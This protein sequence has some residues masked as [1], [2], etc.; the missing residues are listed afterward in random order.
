LVRHPDERNE[1]TEAFA[2]LE[3]DQNRKANT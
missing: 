3:G 2:F 1:F